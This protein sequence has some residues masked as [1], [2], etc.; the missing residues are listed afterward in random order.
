MD[1]IRHDRL[2][3]KFYSIFTSALETT[4]SNA[5]GMY[6]IAVL[7][8]GA[9][10]IMPREKERSVETQR[11]ITTTWAHPPRKLDLNLSFFF[12]LFF[13]LPFFSFFFFFFLS[14]N[15][16][17]RRDFRALVREKNLIRKIISLNK[18]VG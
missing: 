4:V 6:N 8:L 17:C 11:K 9:I 5:P 16:H 10:F 18:I 15:A 3:T 7:P 12:L 1:L 13:S 14:S 2:R